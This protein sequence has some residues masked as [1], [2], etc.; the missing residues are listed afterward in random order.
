M[1]AFDPPAPHTSTAALTA[2]SCLGARRC[3]CL[4]V[5]AEY[6]LGSVLKIVCCTFLS[7]ADLPWESCFCA[8]VCPA[9]IFFSASLSPLFDHSPGKRLFISYAIFEINVMGLLIQCN[10]K[11]TFRWRHARSYNPFPLHYKCLK[12]F[13]SAV[14]L[15][16]VKG[17]AQAMPLYTSPCCIL[18]PA[19]WATSAMTFSHLCVGWQNG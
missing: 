17:H 9:L 18:E 7:W 19:P 6:G 14:G 4:A 8:S 3:R 10:R 15:L 1:A 13:P 5:S 12:P 11:C 16:L 2:W